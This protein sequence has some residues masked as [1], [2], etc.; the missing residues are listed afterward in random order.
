MFCFTLFFYFLLYS[1]LFYFFYSI[2]PFSILFYSLWKFENDSKFKKYSKFEFRP[3]FFF[4]VISDSLKF[5]FE[6]IRFS[7]KLKFLRISIPNEMNCTCLERGF[8][9][10]T[11]CYNSIINQYIAQWLQWKLCVDSG[12]GQKGQVAAASRG[13]GGHAF[14][15]A[16]LTTHMLQI[17]ASIR[18]LAPGH[19]LTAYTPHMRNHPPIQGAIVWPCMHSAHSMPTTPASKG[20][21]GG[22]STGLGRSTHSTS[23]INSSALSPPPLGGPVLVLLVSVTLLSV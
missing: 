16:P 19:P 10:N 1:F 20:G 6:Y 7:K 2:P 18:H 15:R 13:G 8:S 23:F 12:W 14:S 17:S 5:E 9:W 4:F 11:C 22:Q 3:E 21:R